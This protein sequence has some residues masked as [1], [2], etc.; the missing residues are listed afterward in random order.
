MEFYIPTFNTLNTLNT[1]MNE[2]D[3]VAQLPKL[4]KV[5]HFSCKT[6]K[7]VT[8]QQLEINSILECDLKEQTRSQLQRNFVLLMKF[9]QLKI[10]KLKIE[11]TVQ[12]MDI[13]KP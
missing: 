6:L 13:K 7:F 8:N 4:Q 3:E 12:K 11:S 9:I 1:Q 5:A 2:E 10:K